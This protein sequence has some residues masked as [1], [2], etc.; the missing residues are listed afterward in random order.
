MSEISVS[1]LNTFDAFYYDG[2]LYVTLLALKSYNIFIG[3]SVPCANI[4]ILDP[5]GMVSDL[6]PIPPLVLAKIGSPAE[7]ALCYGGEPAFAD[8]CAAFD[9]LDFEALLGD[10]YQTALDEEAIPPP[11][12]D[13]TQT[14]PD[15]P[16]AAQAAFAAAISG[17]E[18]TEDEI[19]TEQPTAP[20]EAEEDLGESAEPE[21]EIAS[22]VVTIT[23]TD[24]IDTTDVDTEIIE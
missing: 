11:R 18:V 3:L 4:A 10:D 8:A 5:T 20:E 16:Y 17:G 9:S 22:P 1:L 24:T 7:S 19:V 2:E 12:P 15:D 6:K 23:S 13:C 14:I 21:P